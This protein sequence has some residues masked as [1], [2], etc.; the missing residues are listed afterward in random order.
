MIVRPVAPADTPALTDIYNH[1]VTTSIVTFEEQP[2]TTGEFRERVDDVLGRGL[3]WLVA[4]IGDF[5]AGYAYASP[6]KARAAYRHSVESTVY[7]APTATGRG[8]GSALYEALF[9]KLRAHGKI[10]AVMG[11]IALPNDASIRLHEKAGMKKIA[12]F[13]QVGFKFGK[14]VDVAYWQRVL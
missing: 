12:H 4:E 9:G 5:V 14:W 3:P 11:G 6:W 8:I 13:E 1:Y 2:V 7:V 10:H